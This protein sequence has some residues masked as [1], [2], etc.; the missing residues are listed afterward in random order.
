MRSAETRKS[1]SETGKTRLETSHSRASGDPLC[2]A[3]LFA[4]ILLATSVAY[5]QVITGLPPFGSFSGGPDVVD[6]GTNNVHW[7]FPV[8]SKP[9]RGISFHYL[10]TY[11]SS[12]WSPRNAS[13]QSVW[14]PVPNWGWATVTNGATGY[15]TYNVANDRCPYGNYPNFNWYY[16]NV[17]GGFTYVD[18]GG[19]SHP[20]SSTLAVSTW[21]SGA[22]C[23]SGPAANASGVATDGSGFK[24][25]VTAG[26]SAPSGT[27][28]DSA[29]VTI[30]APWFPVGQTP[31]PSSASMVDTNSN[32]IST[33]GT[34][35][36]DTLGTTVLT[37]AGSGTPSSPMKYT[38]TTQSGS[39]TVQV[40]YKA[41]T[42]Q[43]NFGCSQ[44]TEYGAT[45]QNLVSSINLPDGTSY[46][47]TYET[48]PSYPNNVTGRP[49]KVTLPTG[50]YITYSYSGGS[51]GITCTDGST[52][53][54]TRTVYDNEGNSAAWSSAHTENGSAWTTTLTDPQ[55]NQTTFNFQEVALGSIVDGYE[56]ERQVYQGS[57]TSGTLLE[58]V[59]TCYNG[60]T[61]NCNTTAI[62][63]PSRAA[64]CGLWSA[65][66]PRRWTRGMTTSVTA[67]RRR[68]MSTT[69]GRPWRARRSPLT[70]ITPPAA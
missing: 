56:T 27:L 26:S 14:T 7:S 44:V 9:G 23:G 37:I 19:T 4:T 21:T 36:V 18:P 41:Y 46:S 11:D 39:A 24:L 42:V 65:A 52:A 25:T 48:T 15:V 51:N 12:V 59:N 62:P 5:A 64:L 1:K 69:G 2:L 22:P 49:A 61:S 29:G 3:F 20:F 55:S 10:L 45:S 31:T 60:A 38:Y 16:W 13:G 68:W 63:H 34:T 43:T 66:R 35:Y 30:N 53:T 54:L 28:V 50:G 33:N 70:T 17:Y 40:N 58:T 57:S 67:C 32:T 6:N 47:F 8:L